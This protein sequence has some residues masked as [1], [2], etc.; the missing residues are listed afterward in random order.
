LGVLQNARPKKAGRPRSE[1][2]ERAI[3][4]AAFELLQQMG[5]NRMTIEA[6][7]AHAGVGRPTIYRRWPNK[8]AMAVAAILAHVPPVQQPTVKD[9]ITA[10]HEIIPAAMKEITNPAIRRIS[11]EIIAASADNP[12]LAQ[13][14]LQERRTIALDVVRRAVEIGYL[15]ADADPELILDKI[16]GPI[17][18]RYYILG[19]PPMPE[20]EI[21]NLIDEVCNEARP[22]PDSP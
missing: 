6:V 8:E 17:L 21:H 2:A 10:L 13:V 3:L 15:R 11:L 5:L 12:E 14:Y 9:P 20:N 18:Y 1:A 4:Q 22:R 7:A 16:V 19:S